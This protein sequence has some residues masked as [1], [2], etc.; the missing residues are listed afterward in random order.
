MTRNCVSKKPVISSDNSLKDMDTKTSGSVKIK[1]NCNNVR[2]RNVLKKISYF[3]FI[4]QLISGLDFGF[5]KLFDDNVQRYL[6]IF[7]IME[8]V[9]YN[10]IL[11]AIIAVIYHPS[12]WFTISFILVP[13]FEYVLNAITLLCHKENNI[14]D[15][16]SKVSEFC[17]FTK[18][19]T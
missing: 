6:R 5:S 11:F 7:T 19:D 9:T 17:N 10:V 18:N 13:F 14:Y 12:L 15:F 8:V 4:S 3:F 2:N 1:T 16:L